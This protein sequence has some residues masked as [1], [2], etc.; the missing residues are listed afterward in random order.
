MV[1]R[2]KWRYI[3]LELAV[4]AIIQVHHKYNIWELGQKKISVDDFKNLNQ[5]NGIFF[6]PEDHVTDVISQQSIETGIWKEHLYLTKS[7]LRKIC[8]K[9]LKL[10]CHEIFEFMP[11]LL[12]VS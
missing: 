7:G 6:A 11:V 8:W 2:A 1:E 3:F 9:E 10:F 4:R 12:Y 5:G